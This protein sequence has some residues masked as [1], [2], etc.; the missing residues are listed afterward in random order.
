M[1]E[2]I[3]AAAVST[4]PEVWRTSR[5]SVPSRLRSDSIPCSRLVSS[6][7]RRFTTVVKSPAAI[8]RT[9][10]TASSG[11]PPRLRKTLPISTHEPAPSARIVTR[12]RPRLIIR[13]RSTF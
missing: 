4:A 1:P 11:S 13:L 6:P 9:V 7:G 12:P 10:S 2:L 3:S 5:M 8:E